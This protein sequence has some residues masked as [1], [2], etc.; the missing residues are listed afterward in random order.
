MI[1]IPGRNLEVDTVPGAAVD[2]LMMNPHETPTQR[3][4]AT[5]ALDTRGLDA[6]ARRLRVTQM[7]DVRQ[8][9][10]EALVMEFRRRL[11]SGRYDGARILDTIAIRLLGSGSITP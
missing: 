1:P 8:R 9:M 5:S 11:A 10:P 4:R 6:A 7:A 3:Q 2:D